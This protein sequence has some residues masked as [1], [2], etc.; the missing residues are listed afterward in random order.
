MRFEMRD[1]DMDFAL[2]GLIGEQTVLR[3]LSGVSLNLVAG[4]AL[5]LV[6]ESGSGKSTCARLLAR[7]YRPARGNIA[8]RGADGRQARRRGDC[9]PIAPKCR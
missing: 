1:V 8:F 3:A 2:G 7:V 4:R 5:A 6:G 9:A